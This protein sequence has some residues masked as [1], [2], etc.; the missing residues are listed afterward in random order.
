MA[1]TD[2]SNY[3]ND[4][5]NTHYA[6]K[7]TGRGSVIMLNIIIVIIWYDILLLS[8]APQSQNK[9]AVNSSNTILKSM[10]GWPTF[11]QTRD[12]HRE[13]RW[14]D[15]F[16]RC[17]PVLSCLLHLLV[18]HPKR[19]DGESAVTARNPGHVCWRFRCRGD[20]GLVRGFGSCRGRRMVSN[21]GQEKKLPDNT[22]IMTVRVK[23]TLHSA[24][25]QSSSFRDRK[26]KDW[27]M[28]VK[29]RTVRNP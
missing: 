22:V 3:W 25:T 23:N 26:E 1:L 12:L 13:P 27:E 18:L 16:H 9:T 21:R 28:L 17:H 15:V 11:L 14:G 19:L 10:W 6:D 24:L 4:Y 8:P 7:F 2:G 29:R 20:C 5:N